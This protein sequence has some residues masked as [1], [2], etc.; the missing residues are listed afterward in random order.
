MGTQPGAPQV[1]CSAL[2]GD[3]PSAV[4]SHFYENDVHPI[5]VDGVTNGGPATALTPVELQATLN[6]AGWS[7]WL[8]KAKS[9]FL[10]LLLNVVSNRKL[11]TE[12]VDA[13][14]G[15]VSQAIQ[16]I[17]GMINDGNPSNDHAA[18]NLASK[19]NSSGSLQANTIDTGTYPDVIPFAPRPSPVVGALRVAPNPMVRS[20]T[21][22][23]DLASPGNTSV[24]VFDVAGRVVRTLLD[25][26]LAGGHH[27]VAWDGTSDSGKRVASGVY[28]Y[29]IDTRGGALTSRF[30]VMR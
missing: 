25:G 3:Y 29:R 8:D 22:Q 15:T 18:E 30:V 23:F 2:T 19:L 11:T 10:A 26:D 9:E 21:L 13:N 27:S 24:R 5:Q 14:G 7:P 20:S 28:F 16:Q 17:A 1:S 12:V 6:A 4:L